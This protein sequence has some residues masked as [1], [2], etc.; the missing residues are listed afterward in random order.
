MPAFGNA[1]EVII[2]LFAIGSGLPNVVRGSITGS[3]V[4]TSL[5]VLGG[6][7]VFR[8]DE[9][10]DRRSLPPP[11]LHGAGSG[12]CCSWFRRSP[13]GTEI[14]IGMCSTS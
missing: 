3:V 11:D 4:S 9:P 1:P 5:L 7:I 12:C 10:I 2:A 6:A 14:R 13:A 8:R